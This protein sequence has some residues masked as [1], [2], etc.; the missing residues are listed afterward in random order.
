MV[1]LNF[2]AND[3]D[4]KKAFAP[5][6]AGDYMALITESE[7]KTTNAG[8]GEYLKLKLEIC[9]GEYKGRVLFVNL[10][11][12][13]PSEIAEGIARA[14]LSAICRAV[15]VMS[16]KD[17]VDLHNIPMSIKLGLKKKN[18]GSEE[19]ENVIREYKPKGSASTPSTPPAGGSKGS[20]KAPWQIPVPP[21]NSR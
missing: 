20:Q 8:T 14:E 17:S 16:P 12:R 7:M 9:D 21:A 19:M 1:A 5:L 10:N 11:L 15:G 6:P 18:D 2:N 13:N 4:P 3:V